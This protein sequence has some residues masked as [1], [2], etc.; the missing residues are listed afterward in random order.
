MVRFDLSLEELR[1]YRPDVPEPQDFDVFWERTLAEARSLRR[2][3]QITPVDTPLTGIRVFDVTFSGFAGEP[4]R[5]WLLVPAHA[6]EPLP[7]VVEYIGYGGGRGLPYDRLLWASSGFAHFVMDTRGQGSAWGN[8]GHTA[9]PH[10][11]APSSPGFFTRGIDHQDNY[12]YR[13]VFTDAVRA[14][15]T[16]R[17]L[18]QIDPARV[19]AAGMSQGGGIALA[20]AALSSD[21]LA[22]LSDVPFLC[23]FERAVGLTG[24]D[25]YQELVRYLAV[26]RG[27]E[28]QA[29]RTLSY[30]DGV[31]MARR[32]KAPSLF[33]V[34]LHDPICPPSTVF[35]AHNAYGGESQIRIYP[36]NEHEGG[37]MHH[38][39]EQADFLRGL[40]T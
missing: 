1:N 11:S 28:V 9:D 10:G 6:S 27:A 35:A 34:A 19:V 3:V 14:V 21:L 38:W 33:S 31:A 39:G 25:P 8:G 24:R 36:F 13:R 2:P 20:A 17:E 29:F 18:A 30:F 12:Y 37:Q 22:V 32:A 4:I 40:E 5:A 16:V 7:V 26:H 23:N 15:D